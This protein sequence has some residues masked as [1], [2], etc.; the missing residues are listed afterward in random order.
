V[1]VDLAVPYEEKDDAKSRG[2]RWDPAR[3]VWYVENREDLTP[4]A[5]WFKAPHRAPHRP[6]KARKRHKAGQTIPARTHG[7]IPDC[8]CLHVAPWEDCEHTDASLGAEISTLRSL[9]AT[10]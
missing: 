5:R 9:S 1:R 7:V 6:H 4:F 10:W 3:R 8:G 2:A